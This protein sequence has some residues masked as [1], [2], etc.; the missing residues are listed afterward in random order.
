[1]QV[2]KVAYDN[3]AYG[4]AVLFYDYIVTKSGKDQC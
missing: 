1:M 2:A 4:D 3:Q